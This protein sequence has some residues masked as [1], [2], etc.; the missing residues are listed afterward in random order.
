MWWPG[1]DNTSSGTWGLSIVISFLLFVCDGDTPLLPPASLPPFPFLECQEYIC[2]CSACLLFF[3]LSAYKQQIWFTLAQKLYKTLNVTAVFL[4]ATVCHLLSWHFL[5]LILL[6][7]KRNKHKNHF[8]PSRNVFKLPHLL[9]AFIHFFCSWGQHF[10][11]LW[12]A[13]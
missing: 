1:D 4:C 13:F 10:L 11:Q 5:H 6:C 2:S 8:L 7:L 9:F 12:V 3:T